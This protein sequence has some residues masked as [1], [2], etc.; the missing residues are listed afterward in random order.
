MD[1]FF[2]REWDGTPFELFG[3]PHI[4]ALMIVALINVALI[5]FGQR[6]SPHRRKVI[7]NTLASIL[8]TNEALWHLWNWTTGQWTIQTMLPLHL[9][10]IL[11]F[12]SAILLVNKSYGLYEF[13]YLLGIAGA[14]Q[15]L[16]TPDAGAYG[17]PHFRFFQ[18]IISHGSIVTAAI[19]MTAVEGYRPTLQSIKRILI[20]GN[21]YA[22]FVGIVNALLGSNYLFIAH[23]PKTASLLDVLPPW[24]W[25]LP[26]LELLAVIIVGL[27][28]LPFAI[29]DLKARQATP[30]AAALT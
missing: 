27:L 2:S 16:L 22:V 17:F 19:Y 14:L 23:K 15:A 9:C 28:Y 4:I 24:P 7:R 1:Q 18:V 8:I 29:K 5:A 11:V 13:V 21:I 20:R 30:D 10:S 6:L 26:I 3:T 12:M 25:Y